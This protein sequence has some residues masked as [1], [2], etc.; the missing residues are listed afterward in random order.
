MTK[1]MLHLVLGDTAAGVV[2]E[3]MAGGALAPGEPLRFRDIYCVGPLTALG[4]ADAA[5]SRARYWAELLPDAPPPLSEFADEEARYGE[6]REAAR[7]GTLVLWVGAHSSSQLWLQRAASELPAHAPD[8]RI[9]AVAAAADARGRRTPS[10]FEP[11]EFGRLLAAAQRLDETTRAVLAGEWARNTAVASGVRRWVDGR[12]RHH[13]DDFYDR[14]LLA[15]CDEE[16]QPAEQVIGS[17]QWECD[18]FIG[19]VFFAWR[20]RRL[21]ETGQV[22][23]RGPQGDAAQAVV[24]LAATGEGGSARH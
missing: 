2:R 12:I 11:D 1:V 6:A 5:A 9:V 24:R 18:E 14:L 8:V 23:W 21:A 4:T 19:D 3:A 10:Q 16:W 17:A 7:S 20:L 22:L 15:Q 13:G